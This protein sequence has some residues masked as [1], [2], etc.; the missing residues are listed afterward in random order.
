MNALLLH[1]NVVSVLFNK[2]HSLRPACF[3]AVAGPQLVL[4]FMSLAELLLWPAANNWGASRRAAL[5]THLGRYTTL[6]PDGRTCAIWSEIVDH[7]R[8]AGKPIHTADAW[9]A[10]TA[11]QWCISLVTADFRDYEVID[12]L[13]VVPIR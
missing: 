1:T 10:S 3:E 7:C 13:E 6:Y 9:I 2:N 4:S 12:D 8:R 11:L 5:E